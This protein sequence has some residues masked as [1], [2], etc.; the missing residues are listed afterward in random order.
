MKFREKLAREEGFSE[1]FVNVDPFENPKMLQL[2][3][4]FERLLFP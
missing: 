4:T 3:T 1:I 2:I